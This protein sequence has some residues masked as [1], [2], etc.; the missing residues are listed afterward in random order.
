[1]TAPLNLRR[2][3]EANVRH[4]MARGRDGVVASAL[5]GNIDDVC[6]LISRKTRKGTY[7]FTS[8][9]QL[10]MS[11]GAHRNPRILSIPAARD[12]I[13]LKS[14]AFL[15]QEIF[16]ETKGKVA[17]QKVAELRKSLEKNSFDAFIRLDVQNFYPS[18][19]H[20]AIMRAVRRKV[21]KPEILSLIQ[22][23]I[24]TPTL[25][26]SAPR[27]DGQATR[28]VPQGLP[29]SNLLAE[30]AMLR[31][32]NQF[33]G[34][35]TM[36]YIRYVDDIIIL[37]AS[38][39]TEAI[40]REVT[41]ACAAIAL[42]V[43]EPRPT[44]SKSKIGLI[45]HSF[46]YLGYVFA[47]NRITVRAESVSKL[48]SSIARVF[49]RYKYETAGMP[50]GDPSRAKALSECQWKLNLVITGCIF[51]NQRRGWLH[52]FSQITDVSILKSL[53]ATVQNFARR[54]G[55]PPDFQPKTFTRTYWSITSGD[56]G[57][58]PYVPNFNNYT[59]EQK[60]RVLIEVFGMDQAEAFKDDAVDRVFRKEVKRLVDKL[61]RDF[62]GLS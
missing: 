39:D 20:E 52:Y 57:D 42:T 30:V 16:P 24:E 25:P 3:Y 11:K 6:R 53:D 47:P 7:S 19:S 61:E 33:C 9:R 27:L 49:T 45:A 26:D 14:L 35:A 34:V 40:C 55:L 1:M 13:V 5:E 2:T 58:D 22:G 32:D 10:L 60:R 36:K 31:I 28:G 43:H 48:K 8:Y 46:D 54:F 15:I 62:S 59:P 41:A 18:V 44:G 51:D 23:A 17:Q 37:C 38:G 29:V 21:R 50:P 12:R 4:G 56:D